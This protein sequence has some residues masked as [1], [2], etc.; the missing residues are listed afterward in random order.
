MK[1]VLNFLV[2]FCLVVSVCAQQGS[3]SKART[4][5]RT[6]GNRTPI[7]KSLAPSSATISMRCPRWL[8]GA[9]SVDRL[10]VDLNTEAFDPDRDKLNYQ[11]LVTGGNILGSGSLVKWELTGVAPGSFEARVQV[12]DKRGAVASESISVSAELPI[13]CDVPCSIVSLSCPDV[14]EEGEPISCAANIGG[15]EPT[16]NPTYEWS[17][18]S[19]RIRKGQQTSGIEV[20]TTGLAGQQVTIVVML[21]GYPPE[22]SESAAHKVEVRKSRVR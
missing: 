16:V 18:S 1:I 20:D 8:A 9:W 3:R 6:S 12:S 15:G 13:H 10:I 7:I 11:Y 22:C 21:G 5:K 19:G 17:V 2:I 14:V 4:K